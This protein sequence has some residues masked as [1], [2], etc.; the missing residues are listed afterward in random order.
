VFDGVTGIVRKPI[1]GAKKEG[2]EGFF[3]GVGKGLVGVVTRPT[4]GVIDF[5]SSSFEGIKRYHKS[6]LLFVNM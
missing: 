1:E 3:K 6:V 2:V 4:S 5:A